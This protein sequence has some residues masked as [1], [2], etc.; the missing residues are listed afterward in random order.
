[1]AIHMPTRVARPA[2]FK[3]GSIRDENLNHVVTIGW[4]FTD[5]DK[6]PWSQ[7]F[8][9]VKE[10][11]PE[12]NRRAATFLATVMARSV[13]DRG[14]VVVPA[15]SSKTRV[16]D[17]ES[18][19]ALAAKAIA[20]LG[21]E[22]AGDLLEQT[23]RGSLKFAKSRAERLDLI[24]DSYA[25][26]DEAPWDLSGKKV[27]IVDDLVTNGDTLME[28]ARAIR[29]AYPDVEAVGGLCFAKNESQSYVAPHGHTITNG[30]I[31]DA[32]AK[33]WDEGP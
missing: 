7:R 9:S 20:E 31:P 11:S 23:P 33:I 28:I 16:T 21:N 30:H 29:E 2:C 8:L 19:M 6:D 24:R 15:M 4:R 5:T 10:G 25:V 18:V 13:Q 32:Y 27:L 14:L 26:R 3:F 22:Y 17:P 1:M 12:T